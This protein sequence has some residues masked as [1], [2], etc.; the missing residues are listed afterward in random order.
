MRVAIL[1]KTYRQE[2]WKPGVWML[3]TAWCIFYSATSLWGAQNPFTRSPTNSPPAPAARKASSRNPFEQA[4]LDSLVGYFQATDTRLRLRLAGKG[5]AGTLQFKGTRFSIKAG[6]SKGGI[7]GKFD[8]GHNSWPFT[9]TSDGKEVVFVTGNVTNRLQ[10]Q[11]LAKWEGVHQSEQVWLKLENRAGAPTGLLKFGGHEYP[12]SAT[13]EADEIQA[14]YTEAGKKIPFTIAPEDGGLLFQTGTFSEL[15]K[16]KSRA[17]RL[18]V[19]AKPAVEFALLVDDKRMSGQ[20]GVFELPEDKP[21]RLEL[22]ARGYLPAKTN[23]T[24]PAYGELLWAPQLEK[25]PFPSTNTIRWTNELGMVFVPVPRTEVLF[26]IWVT[27]VQDYQTFATNTGRE[28]KKPDF[29]QGRT[30][31]AVN[32]SWLDAQAFCEWLTHTGRVAG[33]IEEKQSYRLPTDQEWS[34]AAGLLEEMAGTPKEKD[35]KIKNLFPWGSQWP[36]PKGSG[37][38]HPLLN[39]DDFSATSPAGSFKANEFGLYDMGGNVWQWCADW[40]DSEEKCRVLRGGSWING[41]A[42]RLQTAFRGD[43][44]LPENRYNNTGFRCVLTLT[45]VP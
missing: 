35:S 45:P 9:A 34:L 24:I 6:L 23:I 36:P 7:E 26:S 27:R 17:S 16:P 21:A 11:P 12:F 37:N 31:P 42:E 15:L 4:V 38:Y 10:R 41:T 18:T 19:Q 13:I 3:W 29:E 39:V 2:T 28:W 33:L 8:D 5:V 40:Y 25:S 43:G 32:V 20:N 30:H 22:R 1:L 44:N 14:V